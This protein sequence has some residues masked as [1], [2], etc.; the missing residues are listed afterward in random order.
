MAFA[1][2]IYGLVGALGFVNFASRFIDDG[3]SA[4]V[5]RLVLLRKKRVGW[6]GHRS[7]VTIENFVGQAKSTS[8][9]GCE[10]GT[11]G[12]KFAE[13]DPSMSGFMSPQCATD[14]LDRVVAY[15]SKNITTEQQG[16]LGPLDL[17]PLISQLGEQ[18]RAFERRKAAVH[19]HVSQYG[20]S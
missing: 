15:K 6:S 12:Q 2:L 16:K 9:E 3:L 18:V 7:N 1:A 8:P 20:K 4:R 10:E 14:I 11:L 17:N 5:R 19:A 13:A